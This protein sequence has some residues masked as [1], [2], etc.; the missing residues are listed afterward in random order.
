MKILFCISTLEYGGAERQ[1]C[2]LAKELVRIGHEVHIA[3]GRGGPHAAR[4]IAGGAILHDVGAGG[5]YDPRLLLRLVRLM[6]RVKPDVVQTCLTQMDVA[7]GAAALLTGVP[8]V[9]REPS[10]G[11]SYPPGWKRVLRGMLAKRA[12]A[13]VSNSRQGDAYWREAGALRRHIV[14]NGIPLAEIDAVTAAKSERNTVLFAGRMDEGKNAGTLVEALCLIAGD[15]DFVAVLCGDGPQRAEL[16]RTVNARGLAD[17]ILFPCY[18]ENIWERMKGADV[19]VSL[20]RYEGCSNVMLE[21]MACGCPLVVSGIAAHREMADD[22][23]ALFVPCD[24]AA[25]AA[26]AIKAS[27]LHRGEAEARARSARARTEH[28]AIESMANEYAA[29]YAAAAK[30]LQ[31]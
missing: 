26:E 24:D 21:A 23:S 25:A 4:L 14:F 29:I 15:I 12:A 9:L 22:A 16:E 13:I 18:V 8:W 17:R 3:T 28:Y 10:A 20:S 7:A 11:P 31:T 6:R 19:F 27:L 5:P 1:L 30:R 2:Y